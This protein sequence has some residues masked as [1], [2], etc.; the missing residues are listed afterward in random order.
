MAI[1]KQRLTLATKDARERL[2]RTGPTLALAKVLSSLDVFGNFLKNVAKEAL[3]RHHNSSTMFC[4]SQLLER[5]P[6]IQYIF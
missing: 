5:F 6:E 1:R 3:L 2:Q 4:Y